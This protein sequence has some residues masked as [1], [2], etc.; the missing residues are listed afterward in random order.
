MTE[1]QPAGLDSVRYTVE[2]IHISIDRIRAAWTWLCL[3]VEP[4][5]A[6]TPAG[7]A[8]G[9]AQAERLEALG[10]SDRAYRAYN[11]KHGMSALPPSPAPA[12]VGIIDAQVAVHTL[13]ADAV[14]LLASTGGRQAQRGADAAALDVPAALDWFTGAPLA[15]LGYSGADGVWWRAGA[16]DRIRDSHLAADLDKLLQ[17]AVRTAEAAAGIDVAMTRPLEHRCPA[18]GRRSL[19]LEHSSTTRTRW[20]VECVSERCVCS[21]PARPDQ[22]ACGC[23]RQEHREGRRHVWPYAE[24]D[25]PHGLLAAVTAA[26]ATRPGVGRGA[27]GH[28]GWQSRNMGGAQ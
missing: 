12:R 23:G 1:L 8:V 24:L 16:L 27:A 28:G 26:T 18:C 3:L 20:T 15:E 5:H 2:Q 21:G 6:T 25:G 14:W 17:R 4:G 7:T 11:L 13:I 22:P 19:Q 9:D 10:H